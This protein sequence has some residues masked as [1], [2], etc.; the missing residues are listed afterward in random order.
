[1]R[2]KLA[3]VLLAALAVAIYATAASA[4]NTSPGCTGLLPVAPPSTHPV[5][6][7]WLLDGNG[8][9]TG[10]EIT[11]TPYAS[12]HYHLSAMVG[13]ASGALSVTD[14]G[15]T[16]RVDRVLLSRPTDPLDV[17]LASMAIGEEVNTATSA[18]VSIGWTLNSKGEVTAARV[19]WIPDESS[20]YRLT[21]TVD[22]RSE[23]LTVENS[24]TAA[25]TD[26]IAL[27]PAVTAKA[28]NSASI[29][30]SQSP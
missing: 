11:W 24:G 16:T 27:V 21:L 18:V 20:N 17:H 25:R 3:L 15:T 22:S 10:V 8:Q 23:S 12:S 13:N 7:G 29:C 4:S 6:L 26:S 14:S 5:S 28:V 30:I 9:V 2:G 1:M 19:A